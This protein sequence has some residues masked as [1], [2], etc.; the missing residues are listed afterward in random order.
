MMTL[1]EPNQNPRLDNLSGRPPSE[2][3]KVGRMI[4]IQA[5]KN[6][7]IEYCQRLHFYWWPIKGFTAN[8]T[9]PLRKI[10]NSYHKVFSSSEKF[11]F[12]ARQ[13]A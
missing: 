7:V 9:F 3:Y 12:K 1:A 4:L 2:I 8:F 10:S 13:R 11:H 6:L 5:V